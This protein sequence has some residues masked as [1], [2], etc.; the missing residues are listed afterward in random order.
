MEKVEIFKIPALYRDDFRVKGFRFGTGEKKLSIVGSLRGNEYQQI[1]ICSLLVN[2]L[3]KLEQEGMLVDGKEVLVVPALNPYSMNIGKRFWPTDNSDINRMF[4]GYSLGETTQRIAAGVFDVISEYENGIQ[5]ASFY[6]SGDFL[7]HVHIMET[8]FEDTKKAKEFGLPY[9]VIRKPR[10]FDTTT[11]NYNW[12]IWET[13]AF[14]LY[15][16]TTKTIDEKS[17]NQVVDGVIRFMKTEGIVKGDAEQ[18]EV[19]QV[20]FND[21]MISLRN[22]QAGI[23]CKSAIVGQH[24]KKGEKFGYVQDTLEGDII[25]EIIAPVDGT[26][27]FVYDN[28]MVNEKTAVCK[29]IPD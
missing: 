28:P 20:L 12:Q 1:Y 23:L 29:I 5:F 10:P 22:T 4:P 8:G 9:V 11:L 6:M 18:T 3:K 15:S 21:D 25:E 17:A 24:M 13:A 14:S 7:P 26:I 16:T 2:K 27:F 19:S